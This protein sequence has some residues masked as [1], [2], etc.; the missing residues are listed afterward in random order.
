MATSDERPHH[1]FFR[2]EMTGNLKTKKK[3]IMMPYDTF[4]KIDCSQA[5]CT[6]FYRALCQLMIEKNTMVPRVQHLFL[7]CLCLTSQDLI[8]WEKTNLSDM[9]PVRQD[10]MYF[11]HFFLPVSL[12]L[13]KIYYFFMIPKDHQGSKNQ[14]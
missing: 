7:M 12:E 8:K 2:R 6:N 14:L 5:I 1:S 10:Y 3:N 13:H 9:A 4:L 11:S